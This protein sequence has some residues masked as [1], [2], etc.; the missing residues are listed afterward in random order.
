MH[1]DTVMTMVDR[2]AVVMY[3]GVIEGARTWSITPGDGPRQLVA[4][5]EPQ[6]FDAMARAS[7]GRAAHL[8]DRR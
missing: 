6:L 1:L 4:V 5:Q 8:H 2:D 7:A 3:P